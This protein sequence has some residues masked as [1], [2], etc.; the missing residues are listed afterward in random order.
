MENFINFICRYFEPVFLGIIRSAIS[1][2]LHAYFGVKEQ[3]TTD[4]ALT[5][6]DNAFVTGTG[7]NKFK[8]IDEENGEKRVVYNLEFTIKAE[9]VGL[10]PVLANRLGY[11][12][13]VEPEAL[14]EPT[15]IE[16]ENNEETNS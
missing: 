1:D 15:I 10:I 3:V 2:A 16:G 7:V 11:V 12:E 9:Y 5:D 14:P 13:P 4:A 6:F 8:I